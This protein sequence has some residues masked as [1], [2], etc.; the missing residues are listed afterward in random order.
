MSYNNSG[1]ISL[2]KRCVLCSAD[3]EASAKYCGSCGAEQRGQAAG[4][5]AAP[6]LSIPTFAPVAPPQALSAAMDELNEEQDKL[7]ILLV[8]ERLFLYMHWLIFLATNLFGVWLALKCYHEYVA[9]EM[10]RLMMASTPLLYINCTALICLVPIKGTR[11]E[12]ARLKERLNFL[13]FQMEYNHL[14]K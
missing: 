14:L 11:R 5:P 1:T 12:I 3:V 7:I 6:P 9:D 8:R 10:T 2:A 4:G 13:R